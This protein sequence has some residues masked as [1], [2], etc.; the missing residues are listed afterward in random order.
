MDTSAM[1]DFVKGVDAVAA[2]L[3]GKEAQI[4]I[5]T[6]IEFLSWPGLSEER[7]PEARA[8]L[9]EYASNGIGD[10]I[11]DY[12]AWLKRTYKLKLPDAV[13]A[14]TAK[15]LNVPLLTRDKGFNKIAHLIDV[16]LI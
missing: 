4:S 14:A 16:R 5:I 12:S 9:N 10:F 11:R 15:N 7:I 13:I 1:V 3:T 2:A 6:E 8:F